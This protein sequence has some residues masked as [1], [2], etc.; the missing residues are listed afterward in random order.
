MNLESLVKS[1]FPRTLHPGALFTPAS[2]ASLSNADIMAAAGM[3]QR[4]AALGYAAF[5]GKMN[6]SKNEGATAVSLLLATAEKESA[7]YPALRKL[8]AKERQDVLTIMSVFAFLDYAR[9]PATEIECSSCKGKGLRKSK[10]CSKC[11]GKGVVR[12]ACK[13]CKGRGQAMNRM[14]TQLQGVPIW[15]HCKRCA[16]RGFERI[17]SVV[18]FR[19]VCQVTDAITLDTWNKSVKKLADFL[20]AELHKE[21]EWAEKQLIKASK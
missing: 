18:V 2:P 6:L 4:R 14:K 16:G 11:C 3:T 20:V 7:H 10:P 9:S 1:H 19:A 13:D 5:A 21:E 12:A 17:A 15:Q 8:S